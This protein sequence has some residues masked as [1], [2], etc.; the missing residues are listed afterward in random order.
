MSK[1][2]FVNV[3]AGSKKA[4][5]IVLQ[6]RDI[7]TAT[8]VIVTA[9][10]PVLANRTEKQLASDI[11]DGLNSTFISNNVLYSGQPSFPSTNPT[12]MGFE[13][14]RTQNIIAI[15]S[16]SE[17]EME[18]VS[19]DTNA[20][21]DVSATPIFGTLEDFRDLAGVSGVKLLT[22]DNTPMS[23]RQIILAAKSACSKMIQML[24]GFYIIPTTYLQVEEGEWQRG[25]TCRY[26]PIIRRSP[27]LARGPIQPGYYDSLGFTPVQRI[28]FDPWTGCMHF[29]DYS[30]S[31]GFREATDFG[32]SIVWSYV[33]G[34]P[35][36]VE[37]LMQVALQTLGMSR[38]PTEIA[39]FRGAS[40]QLQF[41][42]P[43][44]A[45]AL[46]MS[47]LSQFAV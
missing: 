28:E 33:A 1:N 34:Y 18:L 29:L 11:W 21:L 8:P 40:F 46:I 45:N 32:N 7:N 5:D 41:K 9:T 42:D 19:N 31:I 3:L 17:Y 14:I 25:V 4:G 39:A 38:I 23:T 22:G 30:N 24:N 36:V 20:I 15:W 6:F 35:D 27:V 26:A 13:S 16:Q 2:S 47:S 10:I 37:S 43:A 44:K 12:V